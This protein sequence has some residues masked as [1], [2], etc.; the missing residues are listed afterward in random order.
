MQ[1]MVVDDD[2][3]IL[4]IIVN[5]I[6]ELA[7]DIETE[8]SSNGYEALTRLRQKKFDLLVTDFSMPVLDGATLIKALKSV[9]EN[10]RPESVLML[11]GYVEN[12]DQAD[13][14]HY[15]TYMPKDCLNTE[16]DAYLLGKWN[17]FKNSS[18]KAQS[19]EDSLRS[20]GRYVPGPLDSIRVDLLLDQCTHMT[21]VRDVSETGI[22]LVIPF[23]FDTL[24]I[25][26]SIDGVLCLPGTKGIKFKGIVRHKGS[27]GA[28]YVGVEFSQMAEEELEVLKKFLKTKNG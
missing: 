22:G 20:D 4:E 19:D 13:G 21:R 11:S 25:D 3:D 12:D 5:Q 8:T 16:L 17:M 2:N 26:R 24:K 18:L 28:Y 10:K 27:H 1:I 6:K 23:L 14:V 7:L 9:E 15:V